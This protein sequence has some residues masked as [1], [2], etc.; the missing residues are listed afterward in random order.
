MY[1][2]TN[3]SKGRHQAKTLD[4]GLVFIDP[5][6]TLTANLER[7]YAT[8]VG[9]GL[10]LDIENAAEDASPGLSGPE[11]AEEASTR[12][13]QRQNAANVDPSELP[14]ADDRAGWVKLAEAAKIDIKKSWGI[15]RIK[16]ELEKLK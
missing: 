5:G 10:S 2:I 16:A 12:T 9:K 14:A 4:Q 1:K 13:E 15:N 3:N 7:T 8:L 6:F 11:V